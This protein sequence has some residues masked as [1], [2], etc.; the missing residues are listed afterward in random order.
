MPIMQLSNEALT[1]FRQPEGCTRSELV[2]SVTKSLVANTFA[3]RP[4]ESDFKLKYKIEGKTS[5]KAIGS[6]PAM[7]VEEARLIVNQLKDELKAGVSLNAYV[8]TARTPPTLQEYIHNSWLPTLKERVRPNTYKMYSSLARLH[9][10]PA[11]GTTHLDKVT[12]QEVI[13]LVTQ[14][15]QIGLSA[16]SANRAL[17]TIR[18]LY[19]AAIAAELDEKNPASK[20]KLYKEPMKERY[21]SDEELKRLLHVL[22]TDSNQAAGR[23]FRFALFTG[24]RIGEVLKS[25]VGM[26]DLENQTWTIPAA[27][28]KS[29][30]ARTLPLNQHAMVVIRELD[31]DHPSGHL[32][33]GRLGLPLNFVHKSFEK[34]R[35]KANLLD[36]TIHSL[37]HSFSAFYLNSGE[38]RSIYELKT[39]LGHANVRTT[40][41]YS[42]LNTA[43]LKTA[44]D[45]VSAAIDKAL[46]STV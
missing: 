25:K 13:H 6:F 7:T 39:L 27:N 15:R 20:V 42:H 14:L 21:L 38:N 26:L 35:T 32:F 1:H 37:R 24:A 41:R 10:I 30:R 5:R 29:G 40:E 44:T 16:A 45:S 28:S 36:I 33:I 4:G 22:E 34:F 43:T 3:G 46:S 11:M 8:G 23:V 9:I 17:A 31:L 18:A 12:R 2:D 19:N